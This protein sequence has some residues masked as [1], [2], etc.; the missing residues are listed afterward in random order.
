VSEVSAR[1]KHLIGI[2]KEAR[3]PKKRAG[4]IEIDSFKDS[5]LKGGYFCAAC[6][7]FLDIQGG[8]CAIVKSKGEDCNGK[9]SKIIAPFGYCS[10][11]APN[12]TIVKH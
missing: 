11:W 10:L 8:K 3:I 5:D 6:V 1:I 7:Y 2:A 9:F 4:Y 12:R